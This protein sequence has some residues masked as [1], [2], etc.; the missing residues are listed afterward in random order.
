MGP[1]QEHQEGVRVF[2]D[3]SADLPLMKS[4]LL[5]A[6]DRPV[7]GFRLQQVDGGVERVVPG[8]GK[9]GIL[10]ADLV[11]VAARDARLAGRFADISGFR[12]GFQE[13]PFLAASERGFGHV[14]HP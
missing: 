12:Q 5:D 3:R 2:A 9:R 14:F 4:R 8:L 10:A 6:L 1:E 7:A 13:E 11:G